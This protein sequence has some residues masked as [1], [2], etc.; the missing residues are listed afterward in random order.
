MTNLK[1]QKKRRQP[2]KY[3]Q[4][5]YIDDCW[6]HFRLLTMKS[7]LNTCIQ[8]IFVIGQVLEK[9]DGIFD[10]K[11]Y[12]NKNNERIHR[13]PQKY[14]QPVYIDD[15]WYHFKLITMN[16]HGVTYIQSLW[17]LVQVLVKS[18]GIFHIKFFKNPNIKKSPGNP[19]NIINQYT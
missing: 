4:P 9:S 10:L 18:D 2:Q 7:H 12:K 6:S 16:S 19:Q 17:V 15:C 13:Q 11:C 5:V 8:S 3:H 14:H 1:K